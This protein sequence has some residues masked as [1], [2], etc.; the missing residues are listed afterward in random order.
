[1]PRAQGGPSKPN[2]G[3]LRDALRELQEARALE[4][5]VRWMPARDAGQMAYLAEKWDDAEGFLRDALAEKP[6]GGVLTASYARALFQNNKKEE[7]AAQLEKA[8]RLGRT[9]P[10]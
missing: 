2:G 3:R 5:G 10:G 8:R 7:A 1:T 6:G 9:R 4:P